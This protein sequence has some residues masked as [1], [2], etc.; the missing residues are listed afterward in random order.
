MNQT[1][2]FL[3][4]AALAVCCAA[5]FSCTNAF[6]DAMGDSGGGGGK[7][8]VQETLD[9]AAVITGVTVSGS[10]TVKPDGQAQY[11]AEVSGSGSHSTAVNWSVTGA[12]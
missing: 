2:R 3:T 4:G 11:R 8:P 6:H 9:P 1:K 12:S 5:A 7:P 10:G